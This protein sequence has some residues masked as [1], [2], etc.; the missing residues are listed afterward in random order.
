[1]RRMLLSMC[2]L[3][4]CG[5]EDKE[6]SYS[7]KDVPPYYLITNQTDFS[8]CHRL[9]NLVEDYGSCNRFSPLRLSGFFD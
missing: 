7:T 9:T 1:M 8:L 2:L 4:S 6:I 5:S 3:L